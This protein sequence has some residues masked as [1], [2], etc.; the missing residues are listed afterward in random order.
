MPGRAIERPRLRSQPDTKAANRLEHG[1]TM[2]MLE[3]YGIESDPRPEQP[4]D[5]RPPGPDVHG[6]RGLPF[7]SDGQPCAAP[8][9]R[10]RASTT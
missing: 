4:P 5:H 1:G 8:G 10:P 9:H 6:H 3:R 2:E 7:S